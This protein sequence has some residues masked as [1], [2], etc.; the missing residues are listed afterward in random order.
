LED[1]AAD[2]VRGGRELYSPD[3]VVHEDEVAGLVAVAVDLQYLAVHRPLD[4]P[5]DHAVLVPRERPVDVAEAQHDGLD[6]EGLEVRRAVALAGK[7]ARPVRGDRVGDHLLVYRRLRFAYDGPA[8]GGE[9]ETSDAVVSGS[10]K[11]V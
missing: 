3:Q 9:N 11:V 2:A 1:L 8:A 7:L 5:R 4:E 6:A 10:L